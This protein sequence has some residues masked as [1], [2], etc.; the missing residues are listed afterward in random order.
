MEDVDER[1][2]SA[3]HLAAATNAILVASL[4][5]KNGAD[6]SAKNSFGST[7]WKIA[8]KRGYT[9]I[10]DM[11]PADAE[12]V[13][14]DVPKR[15]YISSFFSSMWGYVTGFF[16]KRPEP[17]QRYVTGP[18]P[19]D[20]Q[21]PPGQQQQQNASPPSTPGFDQ[22]MSLPRSPSH[23]TLSRGSSTSQLSRQSSGTDVMQQSQSSFINPTYSR[24]N[25]AA[26]LHTSTSSQSLKGMLAGAGAGGGSVVVQTLESEETAQQPQVHDMV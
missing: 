22:P 16:Y 11:L 21:V 5:L 4:L 23:H 9:K 3:L 25:S 2:W 20:D 7:P 26:S 15:G 24:S 17:P 10:A 19:A 13:E 8:N 1:D 18:A 14:V 6:P 12:E